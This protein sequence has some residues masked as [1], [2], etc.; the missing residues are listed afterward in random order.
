MDTSTYVRVYVSTPICRSILFFYMCVE[1][2]ENVCC[3]Y[4]HAY[5]L[6]IVDK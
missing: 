4:L 6:V 1:S 3:M 2:T 5:L